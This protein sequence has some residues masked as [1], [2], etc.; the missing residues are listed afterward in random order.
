MNEHSKSMADNSYRLPTYKQ[1]VSDKVL[2]VHDVG[3]PNILQEKPGGSGV[4]PKGG[5]FRTCEKYF[6]RV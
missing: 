5:C 1:P 2:N 4:F 6:W 3:V